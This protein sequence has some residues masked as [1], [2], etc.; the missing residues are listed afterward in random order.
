MIIIIPITT[1]T[2][3]R[4][5]TDAVRA[6]NGRGAW[7]PGVLRLHR[8]INRRIRVIGGELTRAAGRYIFILG[9]ITRADCTAWS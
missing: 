8:R 2:S 4:R 7:T 1:A 3:S 9:K 5:G 6:H